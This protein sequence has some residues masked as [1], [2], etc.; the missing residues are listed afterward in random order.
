M[1]NVHVKDIKN[2]K[3]SVILFIGNAIFLTDSTNRERQVKQETRNDEENK[4]IFCGR[5]K[6][7]KT[8]LKFYLSLTFSHDLLFFFGN[9]VGD[10]FS[11]NPLNRIN[12]SVYV[13]QG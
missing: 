4:A 12:K 1:Y 8:K 6:S 2:L 10:K 5:Q 11:P 3:R 7:R 13:I 9:L